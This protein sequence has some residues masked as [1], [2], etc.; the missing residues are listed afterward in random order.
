MEHPF[1]SMTTTHAEALRWLMIV[2]KLLS[3]CDLRGS[4]SFTSV[5]LRPTLT[6]NNQTLATVDTLLAGDR[7]IENNQQ[8]MYS[9]LK[10]KERDS[11]LAIGGSG[12]INKTCTRS[13]RLRKGTDLLVR[14][15]VVRFAGG[16]VGYFDFLA[17]FIGFDYMCGLFRAIR[18]VC[19]VLL[20]MAC[21]WYFW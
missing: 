20:W 19:F 11:S 6:P 10:L 17:F 7:R 3:T 14:L 15:F 16:L 2:E 5:W 18:V 8:D 13:S 1:F 21:G 9:I 4:K 12:T